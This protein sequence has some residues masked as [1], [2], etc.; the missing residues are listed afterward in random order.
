MII[1]PQAI[2]SANLASEALSRAQTA[3]GAGS[4]PANAKTAK[5]SAADAGVAKIPVHQSMM[6]Y[7]AITYAA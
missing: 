3:A 1:T 6:A 5:T 2:I 7:A 4:P